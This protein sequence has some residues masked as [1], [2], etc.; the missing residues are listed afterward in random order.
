MCLVHRQVQQ[1]IPD[2]I[3][4]RRNRCRALDA[5]PQLH[6]D[7]RIRFPVPIRSYQVLCSEDLNAKT[8][9]RANVTGTRH[10]LDNLLVDKHELS[11]SVCVSRH[12]GSLL[13]C[14]LGNTEKVLCLL[15]DAVLDGE[16]NDTNEVYFGAVLRHQIPSAPARRKRKTLH[17]VLCEVS[18]EEDGVIHHLKTFQKLQVYFDLSCKLP[19]HSC[20]Q[21]HAALVFYPILVFANRL[22]GLGL[23]LVQRA[24]EVELQVHL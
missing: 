7:V 24:L 9:F 3:S 15:L 18:S 17:I 10:R 6:G 8:S 12:A 21:V 1:A 20:R 14:A 11:L 16:V 23:T 22:S 4:C 5:K 13:A 19:P 2:G